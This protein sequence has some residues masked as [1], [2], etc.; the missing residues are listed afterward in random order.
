VRQYWLLQFSHYPL[1]Q[2]QCATVQKVQGL[3]PRADSL[4]QASIPS[5]SVKQ[6]ENCR[7]EDMATSPQTQNQLDMQDSG[8]DSDLDCTLCH[9]V[10]LP[11]IKT[12]CPTIKHIFYTSRQVRSCSSDRW[13]DKSGNATHVVEMMS[14]SY[15]A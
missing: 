8:L 10:S 11:C 15:Y 4:T 13:L 7:D 12:N 2:A 6:A 14:K 5:R 9:T 1:Q 3:T